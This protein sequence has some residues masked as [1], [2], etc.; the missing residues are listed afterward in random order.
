MRTIVKDLLRGLL[1]QAYAKSP[2]FAL[3]RKLCG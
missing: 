3:F 2:L 1:M